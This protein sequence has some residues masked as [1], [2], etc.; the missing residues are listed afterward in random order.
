[1][2]PMCIVP[3]G[4]GSISSTLYL[5]FDGSASVSNTRA[6][7]QRF[8]HFISI[9]CGSYPDPAAVALPGVFCSATPA[10]PLFFFAELFLAAVF[11]F[12]AFLS[13]ALR[14]LCDRC[15]EIFFFNA[16]VSIENPF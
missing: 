2:W 13:V 10:Y 11:L 5:G 4:Y 1:M 12:R 3:L 9:F 7:A 6:S 8:C 15:A 14:G 16:G